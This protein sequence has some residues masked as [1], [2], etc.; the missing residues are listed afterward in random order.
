[1]MNKIEFMNELR[2]YLEKA[3]GKLERNEISVVI[4]DYEEYFREGLIEGKTED[5]I[6]ESLGNPKEIVDEIVRNDI[7]DGKY[8]QDEFL[9]YFYPKAENEKIKNEN[10]R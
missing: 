5:E 10:R 3:Y 6:V 1:M 8:T 7:E 9:H 2:Q 4:S